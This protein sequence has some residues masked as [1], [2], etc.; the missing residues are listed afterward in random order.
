MKKKKEE[1]PLDKEKK[2]V[3]KLRMDQEMMKQ[4]DLLKWF[5]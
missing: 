4:T 2:K 1:S 5:N 3:M